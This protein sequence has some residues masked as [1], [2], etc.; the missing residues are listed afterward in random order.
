MKVSYCTHD[1][2]VQRSCIVMSQRCILTVLPLRIRDATRFD[3]AAA[4]FDL[5]AARSDLAGTR[6]RGSW[7]SLR[8]Q[9]V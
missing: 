1:I 3:L 5:A 4:R 9:C 2:M 8:C 6:S 7:R